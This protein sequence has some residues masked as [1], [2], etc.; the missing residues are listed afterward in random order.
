LGAEVNLQGD[1]VIVVIVPEHFEQ[2][3][4]E[5]G[6]SKASSRIQKQVWEIQEIGMRIVDAWPRQMLDA[7]RGPLE[8]SRALRGSPATATDSECSHHSSLIRKTSINDSTSTY[9]G[10]IY[11]LHRS[12]T[13]LWPHSHLYCPKSS[14]CGR[15][16][17]P[18]ASR[19]ST[20]PTAGLKTIIA[21]S[22]VS[23][24]NIYRMQRLCLRPS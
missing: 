6:Y 12:G 10:P 24:A 2:V 15:F 19:P 5:P 4:V 22:F 23:Y 11:I 18:L 17:V 21:L 8:K 20:M 9:H 16:Q 14:S 13:P 3:T 7:K 1:R